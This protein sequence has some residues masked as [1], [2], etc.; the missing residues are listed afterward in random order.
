MT[1]QADSVH[2]GR[3]FETVVE[4]NLLIAGWSILER[5]WIEPTTL[6]QLDLVAED[7]TGAP[8]W[9]ECK[10]SWLSASG[11]NGANRT[12]TVKKAIANAALL[13]LVED[14]PR[15]MLVTSTLPTVG[16]SGDRWLQL[17]IEA[18][19]IDRIEVVSMFPST[20]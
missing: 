8:W 6:V 13:S 4:S 16:A 12:D 10:G 7:A 20:A 17:A 3:S 2:Q 19:W 14:H 15:F 5:R 1:F 9:I 11:R 18:K